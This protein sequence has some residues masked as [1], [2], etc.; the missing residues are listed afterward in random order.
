MPAA[1][2]WGLIQDA[3]PAC[4]EPLNIGRAGPRTARIKPMRRGAGKRLPETY[5]HRVRHQH[6]E[7]RTER[8]PNAHNVQA[9]RARRG[10]R[11]PRCSR[12]S[13]R[14]SR[15]GL[16][17]A[18]ACGLLL[19]LV[20]VAPV[21]AAGLVGAAGAVVAAYVGPGRQVEAARINAAGQVEAARINA[22]AQL[23]A[24]R[25]NAGV[26][27]HAPRP[28]GALTPRGCSMRD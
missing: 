16:H 6:P 2:S 12:R 20:L 1:P 11:T 19:L 14:R 8:Q 22:A 3:R 27:E 4:G 18:A 21:V 13:R 23:E 26:D 28:A 9:E 24:A 15:V 7:P 5:R 17:R 10:A 25:I